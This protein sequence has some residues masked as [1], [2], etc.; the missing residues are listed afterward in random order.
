[1][2]SNYPKLW[3]KYGQLTKARQ[4]RRPL[5]AKS[6][7]EELDLPSLGTI[8]VGDLIQHQKYG[9]GTILLIDLARVEDFGPKLV[10]LFPDLQKIAIAN[11]KAK[12]LDV[13]SF[14]TSILGEEVVFINSQTTALLSR[15]KD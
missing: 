3:Q 4:N 6:T 8:R 11:L 12:G 15:A 9:K 14:D 10:I 7:V 1:M 13:S 5:I 2:I